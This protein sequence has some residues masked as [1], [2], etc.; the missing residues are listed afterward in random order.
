MKA[1]SWAQESTVGRENASESNFDLGGMLLRR[2]WL[3][4]LGG[5]VGLGL[6]YLFFT[7]QIPLY[8]SSARLLVV[9]ERAS[10]EIPIRG[11]EAGFETD[12]TAT[13]LVRSP[14]IVG[15]AV[16][17]HGLHRL[18]WAHPS[19]LRRP[20]R[21]FTR[22]RKVSKRINTMRRAHFY[23]VKALRIVSVPMERLL[24]PSRKQF[25]FVRK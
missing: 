9:R 25:M 21:R 4:V 12:S 6:G 7:K 17:K 23:R 11:V 19:L 2:L 8:L 15:E 3:I 24:I 13:M 5:V 20:T 16:K 10:V 1:A 18:M 22:I 14:L